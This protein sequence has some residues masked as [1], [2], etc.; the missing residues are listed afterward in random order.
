MEGFAIN[1]PDYLFTEV[2]PE[3]QLQMSK[4]TCQPRRQYPPEIW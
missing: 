4:I 1:F 2:Q 3:F